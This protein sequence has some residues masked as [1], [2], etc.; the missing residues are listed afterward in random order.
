[1]LHSMQGNYNIQTCNYIVM[2][3]SSSKKPQILNKIIL[4]LKFIFPGSQDEPSHG[5][6][7]QDDIL[8]FMLQIRKLPGTNLLERATRTVALT[9]HD[10]CRHHVLLSTDGRMV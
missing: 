1:M 7:R 8:W 3:C 10:S 5:L 9:F 4:V 2:R 6:D